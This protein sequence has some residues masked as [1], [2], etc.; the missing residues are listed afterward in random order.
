MFGLEKYNYFINTL[1]FDYEFESIVNFVDEIL[2]K[3][4]S[5]CRKPFGFK[6][7]NISKIIWRF[8]IAC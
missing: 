3:H 1:G 7:I 4:I 6:F 8:I 2:P 5:I